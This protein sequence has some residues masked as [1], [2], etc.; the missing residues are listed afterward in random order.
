[1][2]TTKQNDTEYQG[3]S[4][5]TKP[6][7]ALNSSGAIFEEMDTGAIFTWHIDKWYPEPTGIGIEG[8]D[9]IRSMR[10]DE[11]GDLIVGLM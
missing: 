3:L 5:D 1:M 2:I 9:R 8:A 4:T 11:N 7:L 6:T 10:I